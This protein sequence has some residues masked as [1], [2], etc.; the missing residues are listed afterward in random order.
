MIQEI[1]AVCAETAQSGYS[2]AIFD[3][4]R[5]GVG[6]VCAGRREFFPGSSLKF[7]ALERYEDGKVILKLVSTDKENKCVKFITD[8]KRFEQLVARLATATIDLQELRTLLQV[9][10]EDVELPYLPLPSARVSANFPSPSDVSPLL[11]ALSHSPT[12]E[13]KTQ[14]LLSLICGGKQGGS[15]SSTS[16][17]STKAHSQNSTEGQVVESVADKVDEF[18]DADFPE[19][20]DAFIP[21]EEEGEPPERRFGAVLKFIRKFVRSKSSRPAKPLSLTGKLQQFF[22]NVFGLLNPNAS[23]DLSTAKGI[24]EYKV[25]LRV[26]FVFHTRTTSFNFNSDASCCPQSLSRF[27]RFRSVCVVSPPNMGDPLLPSAEESPQPFRQLSKR[28][29]DI[30]KFYFKPEEISA[31][32]KLLSPKIHSM[33]TWKSP[34]PSFAEIFF[35]VVKPLCKEQ[36]DPYKLARFA[37]LVGHHFSLA[38]QALCKSAQIALLEKSKFRLTP[39]MVFQLRFFDSNIREI[40]ILHKIFVDYVKNVKFEGS[41]ILLLNPSQ[42]ENDLPG[43]QKGGIKNEDSPYI[44]SKSLKMNKLQKEISSLLAFLENLS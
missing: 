5:K 37:M 21:L 11:T 19:T 14:Q 28:L 17:A 7:D 12:F 44:S 18:V 32:F 35:E 10:E 33:S 1:F 29:Q 4:K 39:L 15:F 23:F 36:K 42:R 20:A 9:S 40:S 27:K 8:Q 2:Q 13:I 43:E 3:S 30:T 6:F 31:T 22:T 24:T 41:D 26:V 16:C 25:A 38:A 34:V